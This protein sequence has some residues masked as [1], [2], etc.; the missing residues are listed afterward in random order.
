[1]AQARL[2]DQTRDDKAQKHPHARA[3]AC[4]PDLDPDTTRAL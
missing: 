3:R 4:K 2:E 1:M